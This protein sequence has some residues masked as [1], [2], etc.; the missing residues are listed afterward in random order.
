MP[1]KITSILFLL[2]LVASCN[3]DY[4][5]TPEIENQ[6]PEVVDY[7]YH[8]KPILSDRCFACHG[9]DEKARKANLR[10]D[11]PEGALKQKLKEG[12][13]A[14][15]PERPHKSAAFQRIISEDEKLVM[16]PPESNLYITEYEKAL[17]AKWIEQ[18]AQYKKHWSFIA[19][20]KSKIPQEYS[21][22]IDFFITQKLKEKGLSIS[23]PASS[24]QLLR[25]ISFDLTGLPPSVAEQ[26]DF[27][28][29][30]GEKKIN[31]AITILLNNKHYGERL[32]LDW[33]DLAR[34]ADSHGYQDDGMRNTWPWREWVIKA[35]NDNLPYNEFLTWQLAGDLLDNPTQD[36]L[37]AT[38]F[39]RNHP[40][41]Q[42]GGVI[43]EEYR[44]EY[45]ADRAN[46][47]GKGVMGL[48]FRCA[49]CHDH[50]YDP[51]SQKEYYQ[52][53]A[54]FN[55]IEEIGIAPY[56]G[57]ASPTIT[58]LD[59]QA[60]EKLQQ[61]T[62]QL[63]SLTALN[64][65]QNYIEDLKSFLQTQ[66]L[67]PKPQSLIADFSFEFE[68]EVNVNDIYLDNLPKPKRQPSTQTTIAYFNN[69]K[70][71]LDAN[72]WGHKEVRPEFTEGK[73]GK[74]IRFRGDGG[75]RFNRDL[76]LDRQDEFS[77]S[78]WV[79]PEE[80]N[81]AGPIFG[82]FNGDSDGYRGWICKLNKN[83]TL[84]FQLNHLW[85]DNAIDILTKDTLVFNDW[86]HILMTYDGS[87]T[88]DGLSVFVNGTE[89]QKVVLRDNLSKSLLH[90]KE[91]NSWSNLPFL[92]GIELRESISG[93][94]MDEL[95]VWKKVIS[96]FEVKSLLSTN[97]IHFT[98]EEFAALP[99]DQQ[100][101]WFLNNN[102]NKRSKDLADSIRS[103]RA[104][105]NY[106]LT[107]QPDVMV[108][109][110]RQRIRPT[111]ILDRGAYDAPGEKVKINTPKQLPEFSND[112][113]QNRLGLAQW[114]TQKE[115]PLTARVYVNR[116]WTLCFGKGLV[117]TQED[118]GNQGSLPTHPQLLDHLAVLFVESGWDI[119]AMLKLIVS[120][121]TY[122]QSSIPSEDALEKDPLNQLYSRYPTHRLPAEFIRDQALKAS[123]LLVPTIGGPSVFPYQ[124]KGI[125]AALAT[126]NAIVYQQ[127]SGDSLYRRSIYTVWKRSSPPP[128]MLNFDAP[129][130][131]LCTVRR[132]KTSTPLQALVLMN[133]PQFLEAG[134]KLGERM[135]L[136]G[137]AEIKDQIEFGFR[138][139][140]G[141]FPRPEELESLTQLYQTEEEKFSAQPD[142]IAEWLSPGESEVNKNLD[143]IELATCTFV[144]LTIMNFDE[145]VIKR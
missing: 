40:Q 22:P 104:Q 96:P 65:P 85:P 31:D 115:H 21:N 138:S 134:R 102:K 84:N 13:F 72:I 136:E 42:E 82:N 39:N 33:M 120:S 61:L 52:F 105:I 49:R 135:M 143:Q 73:F 26:N 131:Y 125:W 46:T 145:F 69:T 77:V 126:R 90:G 78:I 140:V 137:G 89:V 127:Q 101:Q 119:K 107:N 100:M 80:K 28:N 86:N 110:E 123:G 67:E 2:I 55:N 41:S 112:L 75:I 113:P 121:N 87:S 30:K 114:L 54:F 92:L 58:L 25:R 47:V 6:L 1:L 64:A 83:R 103:K 117:E 18:G 68:K 37:I 10:L 111:F 118:F 98:A 141:R 139:L 48:T 53:Y 5:V 38:C 3:K 12:G 4:E 79:K 108:M 51:I 129:D 60:K 14:F 43:D 36:Q 34:Y 106:Y 50:K 133:D 63:D 124:P 109:K 45:V 81:S 97:K 74:G 76:D 59:D 15:S 57:E 94:V 44:S 122:Q 29:K 144:A 24:E 116:L 8:I 95:K 132:Q 9:P 71:K 128:S 19:P 99:E 35:F 7:N 91:R 142:V 17:I 16:P 20:K 130:R 23:A 32:A 11:S 70:N 62:N 66:D 93:I 88:A 56:N 27:L